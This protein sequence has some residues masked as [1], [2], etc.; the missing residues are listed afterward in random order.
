[1]S[2]SEYLRDRPE[3]LLK[4]EEEPAYRWRAGINQLPEYNQEA[5][6]SEK[7]W[8]VEPAKAPQLRL[9]DLDNFGD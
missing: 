5:G 8:Y 4:K 1:M 3:L 2:R 7:R 6:I 9:G